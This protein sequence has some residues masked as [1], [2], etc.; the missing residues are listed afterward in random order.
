MN[1]IW[2]MTDDLSCE[3]KLFLWEAEVVNRWFMNPNSQN[4]TTDNLLWKENF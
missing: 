1:A 3:K 2:M 4:S